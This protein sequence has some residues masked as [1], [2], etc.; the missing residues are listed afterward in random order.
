MEQA[1]IFKK[2]ASDERLMRK[3]SERVVIFSTMIRSKL[4]SSCL[5]CGEKLNYLDW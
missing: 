5:F 2:E 1:A 3:E 4:L